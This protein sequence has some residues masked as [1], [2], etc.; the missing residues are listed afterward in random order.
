KAARLSV[1]EPARAV[2]LLPVIEERDSAARD[3]RMARHFG[4]LSPSE[5]AR[6]LLLTG[7]HEARRDI[8]ERV[9][10]ELR[11]AGSGDRIRVFRAFDSQARIPWQAIGTGNTAWS[12]RSAPTCWRYGD[13]M[14]ALCGLPATGCYRSI[15]ATQ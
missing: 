14:T 11:L 2:Q 12:R 15:T 3:A 1:R 13:R 9:R 8:N 7:S 10:S 5:Q 4:A 6:T